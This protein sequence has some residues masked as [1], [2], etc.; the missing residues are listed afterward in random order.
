MSFRT[1]PRPVASHH[2]LWGPILLTV[3]FS[4]PAGSTEHP[5][6]AMALTGFI[7]NRGQFAADVLFYLPGSGAGVFFTSAGLVFDLAAPPTEAEGFPR[8]RCAVEASFQ[9]ANP[10]PEV[11]GRSALAT[12][13]N[14]FL[15]NREEDW[16]TDVPSFEEIVYIG[17]WPGVDLSFRCEGGELT[18]HIEVSREG[19]PARARFHYEGADN[20]VLLA[21]GA[22]RIE[23]PLASITES[24]AEDG[25]QGRFFVTRPSDGIDA[26][27]VRKDGR[28]GL[29]WSTFLGGSNVD[30]GWAV[31]VDPWHVP[32]VAGHT[33]STDFPVTPGYDQ[34][35]NGSEDCFV[36]RFQSDGSALEWATFIGGSDDEEA[37]DLTVVTNWFPVL[38]G[39]TQST[40]FPVTP[41]AFDL[42][43]NGGKDAF[44]VQLTHE[45]NSLRC[46]T[47]LG[48][49]LDDEASA[50]VSE[51]GLVVVAGKTL[52]VDFPTTAGA[53]DISYNFFTDAFVT[54]LD[55]VRSELTWST[56]LGGGDDERATGLAMDGSRNVVVTG[57][58][59]SFEFPTT[60]GSFDQSHNGSADAFVLK[61]SD[62][63][64]SLLWGTF[65][66]G[67]A[68][69]EPV[70]VA[71]DQENDVVF[72]GYTISYDYPVTPGSYQTTYGEGCDVFVTKLLA[73]GS[74]PAFSTF[75]GG[76]YHDQTSGL[77]LDP[78][79]CPV[80]TGFTYGDFPTTPDA[81]D[82]ICILVDGFVSKLDNQGQGLL[83]S[84][85]LG[86][87]S[88]D[89]IHDVAP[90]SGGDV[91]VTG[92]TSSSDFPV[93]PGASDEILDGVADAFLTR[94]DLP[95][96]RIWFI[97]PDGSGDA[98]TVQAGIDSA[99][100]G[101]FVLLAPGT[102]YEHDIELKDYVTVA[103]QDDDP[104]SSIIDAQGLGRVMSATDADHADLRSVTLTGGLA[105]TGAGLYLIRSDL[106]VVDCVITDNVATGGIGAGI[107]ITGASP[108][109]SDCVITSNHALSNGY[110]GGVSC[111]VGS[112]PAITRCVF[113]GNS[114]FYG[115]GLYSASASAPSLHSCTFYGNA[116]SGYG[117]G[118][119]S[120]NASASLENTI[121]ASCAGG[122][123]VYCG[124][125]GSATLSCCDLYGNAGGD[126]VGCVA[127]QY[128][129][130]GNISADPLF[131]DAADGDYQLRYC[132]PC[133]ADNAPGDCGLIGAG[134]VDSTRVEAW[135]LTADGSGDAPTIQAALDQSCEG[136]S[137]LLAC[138]TYLEGEIDM[139]SG[140][141]VRGETGHPDCA[142]VHAPFGGS[143]FVCD[144]H[145][146][147]TGKLEALTITGGSEGGVYCTGGSPTITDCI[148]TG[149][150]GN[151]GA[152][153]ICLN[154]SDPDLLR[155]EIT[156]NTATGTSS[157]AA[158]YGAEDSEPTL[159]ECIIAHNTAA[160]GA[161]VYGAPASFSAVFTI[162]RC[163][164]ADNTTS[165]R[166]SALY[167]EAD[168]LMGNSIIAFTSGGAAV[169]CGT[170]G[171]ATLTCCDLYGNDGGD[172]AYCV[173][174]QAG[175]GNVSLDPL[176]CLEANPEDPY[177]LDYDSPCTASYNPTCGQIGAR[178]VGCGSGDA[179]E[180]DRLPAVFNLYQGG[181]MPFRSV[182]T[183]RC[184][185]PQR[186]PVQIRVYDAAGRLVR[187]LFSSDA[188]GPGRMGLVWDGSDDRG[189]AVPSG[190]YYCRMVAGSHDFRRV[191][192]CIR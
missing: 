188:T 36:A 112:A 136:D 62:D 7:E 99:Q 156:Y 34:S 173:E 15:G 88:S 161:A 117:G 115:G 39:W 164:I 137:I 3:L 23:T 5:Q 157:G 95:G 49:S 186:S 131:W 103:G 30:N 177:S 160:S 101:D 152:G 45:G 41:D 19:D 22:T 52:S 162:N 147:A 14:Y 35:H 13:Y 78:N 190:V 4:T 145:V 25:T 107:A 127:S 67:T 70:A 77:C 125:G 133:A 83:Y 120:T 108:A 24:L 155:C 183:L 58:T 128:G 168:V 44:V 106:D 153:V 97:H 69:D 144:G 184:D 109:I 73:D 134:W 93:T 47:Y 138:G 148:I 98:P 87:G 89:Y 20:V 59:E 11:V 118:V 60:P 180:P 142:I 116:D 37:Q 124:G 92:M 86:G 135:R 79:D 31:T 51:Y 56:F 141:V 181:P 158:V 149:N 84:S 40:N 75:L 80:V 179:G 43:P 96:P 61:L 167:T 12:R 85:Y 129:T 42:T 182:T 119:A 104:L 16:R 53:Y 175:H 166:S 82:Q 191:L 21:E 151:H 27:S 187:D 176:F 174:G 100:I 8:G 76:E 63:G 57:L 50:I 68:S 26:P 28:L 154:R 2:P 55:P 102:F 132:S 114:S 150:E 1:K 91:I 146:D 140:I 143:V 94:M 32:L 71:L 9:A 29:V 18:Y 48:G 163:T 189:L 66:G 72:A 121:I 110:G 65:Y 170:A 139:R 64:T 111:A 126:W 17:A 159:T 81:Y 90:E 105:A 122:S 171:E 6:A 38:T 123:A 178:G 74:Y 169:K 46:S 165:T 10:S 54:E 33:Y 185:L 130:N 172:W 192:V 113:A